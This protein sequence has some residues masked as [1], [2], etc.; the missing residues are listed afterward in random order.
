[1]C[2]D[3]VI[4]MVM[5]LQPPT[6]VTEVNL[7]LSLCLY[8]C[9]SLSVGEPNRVTVAAAAQQDGHLCFTRPG[10]A[11]QCGVGSKDQSNHKQ[12]QMKKENLRVDSCFQKGFSASHWFVHTV[13]AQRISGS[14]LSVVFEWQIKWVEQSCFHYLYLFPRVQGAES[15]FLNFIAWL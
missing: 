8:L 5:K 12:S 9:P 7:Y 14:W 15:I 11:S 4:K 10:P 3:C 2:A 6:F 1:M 13:S